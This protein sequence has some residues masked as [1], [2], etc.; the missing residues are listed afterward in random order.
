MVLG[1]VV[2]CLLVEMATGGD[3]LNLLE[4]RVQLVFLVRATADQP[5][6]VIVMKFSVITQCRVRWLEVDIMGREY[7]GT[8]VQSMHTLSII[9]CAPA[10]MRV[11][12]R[13]LVER[14]SLKDRGNVSNQ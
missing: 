11:D 14:A 8:A 13:R 6:N 4:L 10:N 1:D 9:N 12:V 3:L 2:Q 5:T 7:L